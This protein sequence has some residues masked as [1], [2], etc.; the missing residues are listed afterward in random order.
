M[1]K[2]IRQKKLKESTKNFTPLFSKPL[3]KVLVLQLLLTLMQ[4]GLLSVIALP[5][6]GA[7]QAKE[8]TKNT[9]DSLKKER[10]IL[11]NGSYFVVLAPD[12]FMGKEKEETLL[13]FTFDGNDEMDPCQG[14]GWIKIKTDN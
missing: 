10:L 13:E 2:E 1:A 12:G 4:S 7:T 5:E 6:A 9:E 8:T 14:R 11:K 3:S